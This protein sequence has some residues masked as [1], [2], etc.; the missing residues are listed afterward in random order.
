[1]KKDEITGALVPFDFSGI[2]DEFP[3]LRRLP[4]GI[5]VYTMPKLIDSSNAQP[6]DWCA[7]AE[8]IR[9]RYDAYTAPTLCHTPLRP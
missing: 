5:S 7:I 3:A 9:N 1:M 8:V 4:V 6:S 2:Y